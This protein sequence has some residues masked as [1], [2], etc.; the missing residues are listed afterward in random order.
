M[1]SALVEKTGIS[2]PDLLDAFGQYLFPKLHASLPESAMPKGNFFEFLKSIDSVIHVEV[3]KLD[4]KA[5]V[6]EITVDREKDNSI[7]LHYKSEKKMCH[8]AI[9]LLKGA[10]KE[11]N[12]KVDISMPVCMHDGSNYCE[13]ILITE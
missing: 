4:E 5:E 1:V 9:G 11:F 3:K 2:A 12:Q 6:P 8:L 13:L 10:A 7:V